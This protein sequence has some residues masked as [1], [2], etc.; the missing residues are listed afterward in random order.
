MLIPK[1]GVSNE[2]LCSHLFIVMQEITVLLSKK[3]LN[4]SGN[5]T[6]H[7]GQGRPVTFCLQV[8]KAKVMFHIRF[9]C[10]VHLIRT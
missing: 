8:E 5:Y 9:S 7:C 10:S 6:F 2:N 4:S 1:S 3:A